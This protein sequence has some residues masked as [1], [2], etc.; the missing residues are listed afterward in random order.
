MLSGTF[1]RRAD[2]VTIPDGG[3]IQPDATASC[4]AA[5]KTP[6]GLE[7]NYRQSGSGGTVTATVVIRVSNPA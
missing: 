5:G 3:T 6:P 1:V 4:F 7:I 2:G